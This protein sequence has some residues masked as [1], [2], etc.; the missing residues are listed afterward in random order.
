MKLIEAVH[1]ILYRNK[2]EYL[3]IYCVLC[4][5]MIKC[6][7]KGTYLTVRGRSLNICNNFPTWET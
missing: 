1:K 6:S 2:M 3:A 7:S 4:Q 5:A